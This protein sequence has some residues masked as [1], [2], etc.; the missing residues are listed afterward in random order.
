MD[1]ILELLLCGG[2]W[3]LGTILVVLAL[4][5]GVVLV[6]PPIVLAVMIGLDLLFL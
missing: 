5:P 6:S 4:V 3:G 2:K 1:N